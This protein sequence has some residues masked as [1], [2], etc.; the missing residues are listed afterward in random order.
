MS[1]F[2]EGRKE[3]MGVIDEIPE[4]LVHSRVSVNSWSVLEI[5]EHLVLIEKVITKQC[6]HLI[7]QGVDTE[8]PDHPVYRSGKRYPVVEAPEYVRPIGRYRSMDEAKIALQQSRNKL[9]QVLEDIED[10]T[11][12]ERRAFSHPVFG[13]MKLTQWIDFIGYHERRHI[14][15]IKEII[16]RNRPSA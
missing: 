8:T 15:Q 1:V 5:L 10:P 12:L 11:L 3:L 16:K 9:I 6:E 7:C 2:E 4:D 13:P 14:D